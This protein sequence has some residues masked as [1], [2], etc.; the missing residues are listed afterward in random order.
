M[1]PKPVVNNETFQLPVPQLVSKN[2]ISETSTVAPKK[3]IMQHQM[4]S[5]IL[6]WWLFSTICFRFFTYK[7][8]KI[9]YGGFLKWWYPKMDG[10]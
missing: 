6:G 3:G 2:R 9:Y 5:E 8:P 10:L 4:I 7:W 1:Y